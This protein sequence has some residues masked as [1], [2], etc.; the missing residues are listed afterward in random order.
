M[1]SVTSVEC[2]QATTTSRGAKPRNAKILERKFLRSHGL[3]GAFVPIFLDVV[4]NLFKAATISASYRGKKYDISFEYRD[5]WDWITRLL[6]DE[7]LG[8]HMMFNSVHKYYCEGTETEAFCER[9]ID[10]PNTADTWDEYDSQ[11]PEADPYPH[12]LL[13]L[14]FWLDEGLVTKRV[15]MHPMVLRPA[16]LPGNIRNAFGNGGGVLIGY[17]TH[18]PDPRDPSDRKT[19]DTLEFAKFKMEVYQRVR[20][21][22]FSSLKSRSWNATMKAVVLKARRVTTKT[23]KEELLKN[24]GLHGIKV[25]LDD[26]RFSGLK[27]QQHFLWGFRFSDP[28][29]AYS[30]DTLHSDDLGK[31]GDHLWDFLLEVL[32]ELEGKG[33]FAKNSYPAT[34][35]IMTGMHCMPSSRLEHLGVFIQEYEKCCSMDRIDETQEAIARIRMA[36]DK[37]DKQRKEDEQEEEPEL[38]DAPKSSQ[39]NSASWRFGAPGRLFNSRTFKEY[40]DS[41]GHPVHEFDLL[42]RDFITEQFPDDRVSYEQHIQTSSAA[43]PSSTAIL[44]STAFFSI[45]I[46]PGWRSPVYMRYCVAPLSRNAS[47]TSLLFASI[48]E[49]TGSRGPSGQDAK[50]MRR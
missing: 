24:H 5:P 25:Q 16:F 21:D 4:K 41:I 22:I 18:V 11:L 12:C 32:E 39:V 43:T 40:L 7:T 17:M 30:Y 2:R 28:Y 3:H 50:C 13:P 6:E 36:I 20:E 37:Y 1:P 49:A 31:L 35:R 48:A 47:S 38:D 34:V 14:H 44:D 33:S 45:P 10:E 23:A 9:V 29:A 27:T 8:P 15:S 46:L 26:F 19:R 42:L